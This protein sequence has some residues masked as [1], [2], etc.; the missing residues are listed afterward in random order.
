[1]LFTYTYVPHQMEKMQEFIDFIFHEVWCKAPTKGSYC[2]ELYEAN[3][4]LNDVMTAF[5]CLLRL[6]Q[7]ACVNHPKCLER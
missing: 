1:M 4:E 2:L 7:S 6:S 5:H 3:P